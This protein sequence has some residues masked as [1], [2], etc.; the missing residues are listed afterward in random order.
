[1]IEVMLPLEDC[2]SASPLQGMHGTDL[3]ADAQQYPDSPRQQPENTRLSVIEMT[4]NTETKAIIH[5]N[6]QQVLLVFVDSVIRHPR[7]CVRRTGNDKQLFSTI[8]LKKS[9]QH[10]QSKQIRGPLPTYTHVGILPR[11]EADSILFAPL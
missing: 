3:H 10:G 4:R 9:S 7:F 5:K 2:R 8:T 1:M 11:K 6:R